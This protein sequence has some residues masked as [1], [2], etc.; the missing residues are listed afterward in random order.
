MFIIFLHKE[1]WLR[2]NDTVSALMRNWKRLRRSFANGRV[3]TS[4]LFRARLHGHQAQLTALWHRTS[5]GF[6]RSDTRHWVLRP[7]LTTWRGPI[8]ATTT[9]SSRTTFHQQTLCWGGCRKNR[10]YL[11]IKC[12]GGGICPAAPAVIFL[13]LFHCSNQARADKKLKIKHTR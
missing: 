10:I 3:I 6:I 9:A 5:L 12:M 11:G 13:P 7:V 2:F 4:L 1:S 8:R